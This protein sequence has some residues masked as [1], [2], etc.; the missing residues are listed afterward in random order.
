[1]SACLIV[2]A[3][4]YTR[5]EEIRAAKSKYSIVV[6]FGLAGRVHA[7]IVHEYWRTGAARRVGG[8]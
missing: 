2:S 6:Y 7:L 1:M 8:R 4:L 5:T 3:R